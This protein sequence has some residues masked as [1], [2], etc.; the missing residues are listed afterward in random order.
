[1]LIAFWL[2]GTR[3]GLGGADIAELTARALRPLGMIL[4]V[5]GAGGFFGEVLS[6][7]GVGDALA[8]SLQAT[9]LP[10]I[11][12]AYLI[13]SGMRI[14]QGSATV[15]IVTTGGIVAP[16]LAGSAYSQPQL[17]LVAVAIGAGSIIAS[18]V[19]DG[20]FWIISRY[21]GIPVAEMLKTWTVLET[22]LSLSAF[23]VAA[24]LSVLV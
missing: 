5:V 4:L 7:T 24:G 6:E 11:A 16:L 19:N 22:I 12:S 23:A 17:A 21:F 13:S 1:M 2:L 20:G 8:G 3:R 10:V 14:A 15:A 9:G 18:H